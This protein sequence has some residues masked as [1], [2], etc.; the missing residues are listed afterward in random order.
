MQ[1]LLQWQGISITYSEGVFV[2]LGIQRAVR[3]CHIV[4]CG[5]SGCAVY[6]SIIS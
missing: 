4:I 3:V 5:L 6:V 1:P 2:P